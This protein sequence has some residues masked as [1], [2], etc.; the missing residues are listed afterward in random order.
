MI[1][2]VI[3]AGSSGTRLWPLSRTQYPKQFL[4]LYGN[5]TMLK[6]TVKRL[7]QLK[8][9]EPLVICNQEHR[10]VVAEQ[11]RELDISGKIVLEPIGRNTA[12]AIAVAAMLAMREAS[13]GDPILLVLA[14][15]HVIQ[16]ESTFTDVVKQAEPIASLGKLITFGVIPTEAHTGYGYIRRGISTDGVA[17]TVDGFVEKPDLETAENM[18]PLVITIG[19]VAYLCFRPVLISKRSRNIDPTSLKL[20]SWPVRVLV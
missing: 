11:L 9:E 6:T 13:G 19:T 15:D 18:F 16:N 8:I 20:V 17:F 7:E 4:E 14:A 12:P 10:F 1:F 5:E 3:M 2:P